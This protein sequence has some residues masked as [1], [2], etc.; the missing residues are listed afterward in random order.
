MNDPVELLSTVLDQAAALVVGLRID[1]A[2]LPTPCSAWNVAALVNHLIDDLG[3]FTMMAGG[4]QPD[5][6]AQPSKVPFDMWADVFNSEARDVLAAW[7]EAPDDA[8]GG[9][10]MQLAEVVAHGWDIAKASGQSV[11]LDADAAAQGL[12]WSRERLTPERRG[13]AFGPAVTV[14][15]GVAP[16]DQLV[17]WFGR[18]PAWAPPA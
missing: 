8:R 16:V 2:V 14:P 4:G 9:I 1:Q 12:A 18:N 7:S 17:A 15:E 11:S 6:S 3:N 5:W 10:D 13:S